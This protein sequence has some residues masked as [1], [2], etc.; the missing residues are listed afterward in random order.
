MKNKNIIIGL[1]III[2]IILIIIYIWPYFYE[3]FSVIIIA[4]DQEY[5]PE[6][7]EEIELELVSNESEGILNSIYSFGSNITMSSADTLKSLPGF[8]SGTS[9]K[10]W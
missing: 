10:S 4:N 5:T 7:N 3:P 1:V 8:G 2:I 6:Y 9:Y